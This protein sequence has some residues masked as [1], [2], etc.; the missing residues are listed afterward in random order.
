MQHSLALMQL[1]SCI[2]MR[3][4]E[5]EMFVDRSDGAASVMLQ[6]LGRSSRRSLQN[7]RPWLLAQGQVSWQ[8]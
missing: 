6:I 5:S 4:D 3:C 7:Y 1:D 2:V 8:Q